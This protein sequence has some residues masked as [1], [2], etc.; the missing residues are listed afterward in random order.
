MVFLIKIP[1]PFLTKILKCFRSMRSLEFAVI[2]KTFP[3]GMMM[4]A[5]ARTLPMMVQE[6]VRVKSPVTGILQVPALAVTVEVFFS[7][8]ESK[9]SPAKMWEISEIV[10]PSLS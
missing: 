4:E 3:D 2:V 8:V 9:V 7:K 5:G 10:L 6:E 1:P